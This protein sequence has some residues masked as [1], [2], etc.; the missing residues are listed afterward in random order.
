MGAGTSMLGS[1]VVG[2]TKSLGRSGGAFGA[3]IISPWGMGAGGLISRGRGEGPG[4]TPRSP[5]EVMTS[6]EKIFGG[7]EEEEGPEGEHL[8]PGLPREGS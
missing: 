1:R 8:E 4:S 7:T 6:G 3:G 2:A 5:A